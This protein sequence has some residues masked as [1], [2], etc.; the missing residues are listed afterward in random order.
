MFLLL[1]RISINCRVGSLPNS[2][3]A[4]DNMKY[5]DV[6]DYIVGEPLK[7]NVPKKGS[8]VSPIIFK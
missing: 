8:S 7:Q 4:T 2:V 3:P 1:F 5:R 6:I